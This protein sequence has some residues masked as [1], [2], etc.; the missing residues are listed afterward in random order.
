MSAFS[1]ETLEGLWQFAAEHPEWSEEEGGEDG[2]DQ[3]VAWWAV[4]TSRGLLLVDPLV[5]DWDQLDAMIADH[6]GCAGI[7]RTIHWHERSVAEAAAR[8]GASVWAKRPPSGDELQPF[9]RALEDGEELWDG[10][11]ACSVERIDE[12]ALWLP[13][14]E[15]LVFGDAMLRRDTGQLR[16]SPDSWTQ[17]EGGPARLRATLG[18]LTRF[19]IE[20][21]LV[22]HGP[23]VLGRG[24][25]SLETA[26]A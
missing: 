16:V 17:P 14:Q 23:L 4:A 15:A 8:Y 9:D 18:R 19:P 20:H 10:I 26:L 21:V 22:S 12:I 5:P 7:V 24:L 3:V 11:R 1:G 6:G 25:E 13:A 2:W